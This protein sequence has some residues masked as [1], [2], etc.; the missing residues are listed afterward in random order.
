MSGSRKKSRLTSVFA[1]MASKPSMSKMFGF[2]VPL[3]YIVQ[4][5]LNV[6]AVMPESITGRVLEFDLTLA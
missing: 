6:N 5:A 1:P 2:P 4:F 3:G